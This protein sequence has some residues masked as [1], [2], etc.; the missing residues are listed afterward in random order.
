MFK[1]MLIKYQ[2]KQVWCLARG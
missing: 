2:D 1:Q